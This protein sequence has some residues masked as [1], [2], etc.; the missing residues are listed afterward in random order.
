MGGWAL[1]VGL[2]LAIFS[3]SGGTGGGDA[4]P[5]PP[6][7]PN[8]TAFGMPELVTIIGY[9]G[10][11]MEP[12]VSRDGTY[13]FFNN[14]GANKDI[15]YAAFVNPT[16]AQFQGPLTSINSAAVEGT[17]TTDVASRFFYVTTANYSPP[18]IY[19]T[20]YSGTWNGSS[21]TG[22][23]P[24]SGLAL[25]IPG[26]LIFDVEVSADGL[27][28]LFADGDFAG[29]DPL[30][31]AAD[32]AVAV[33]TGAGFVRDPNSASILANI[34]TANG[35]EYAPAL[36]ADGLELFFTRL[37]PN[38]MQARIYRSTRANYTGAFGAP[39]LVSA[40]TG[41]VEGP[42]LSPDEKSLYYHRETPG[43]GRFDIYR[44]TR[45]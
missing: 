42:A 2:A 38:A 15:F 20:L 1:V 29:G 16:T 35:L 12:F 19:D 26:Q 32:I 7:N 17:P 6:P 37:D 24:V 43:A 44:V 25:M 14:N 36:S 39:Q 21:V 23:A 4:P 5:I 11:A 3:C 8:Y 34:N 28:L 10:D 18:A 27:T 30:P 33:S 13:L 40:V 31:A 45:P 9:D 22:A 41:F